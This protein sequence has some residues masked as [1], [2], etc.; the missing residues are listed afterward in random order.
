MTESPAIGVLCL[1]TTFTKIPGHIRNPSTFDFPVLYQVVEGATA[2][3]VVTQGD[4]RLLEP[5]SPAAADL[6]A[7]ARGDH[8]RLRIPGAVPGRAGCR[9]VDAGV[10]LQPGATADGASDA[11]P[12]QK[13]GLLVA[14]RHALTTRHLAAIGAQDVPVGSPACRTS[15]SSAR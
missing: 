5:F 1:E 7:R 9:G 13:V 10:R 4:P 15:G 12:Q 2:E 6:Q 14:N 8:L 11:A 3:R